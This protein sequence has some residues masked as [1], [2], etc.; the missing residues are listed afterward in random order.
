M[1]LV[2][3]TQRKVILS[4]MRMKAL[5]SKR[6]KLFA[7]RSQSDLIKSRKKIYLPSQMMKIKKRIW[8]R[9]DHTGESSIYSKSE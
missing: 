7:N 6:K 4:Q 3:S 2:E 9:R 5:S 1:T 8:R